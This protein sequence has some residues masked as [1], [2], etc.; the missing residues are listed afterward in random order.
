MYPVTQEAETRLTQREPDWQRPGYHFLPPANWLNDPNGLMHWKGEYHLFYQ[1]NP[2]GPIHGNIH[3]GHAVSTDLVHW[4]HLPIALAP[5]PGSVDEDGCW[6][7]CAIDDQGV[8]TLIYTGLRGGEQ[9]PCLAT[10]SDDL[11]TWQKCADN[12]IIPAPPADLEVIG[13]RDHSLWKEGDTWY[14]V[15]GSGIKGVGGTALLYRSSNLRQ[16]EYLHPLCVG[17]KD[18]TTPVWL[19]S[20]WEC[21]DFFALGDKHVLITSI[22]HE[23]QLHYTVYQ[24]GR[25]AAHHF[26]PET[27]EKLDYGD[28]YFYAPQTVR[29]AQGRR[30]IWGWIQEGRSKP[31]QIAAG[32]SGV[33]SLPRVLSLGTDS[34][35]RQ[36]P[37]P[38]LQ[39]LRRAHRQVPALVL[40]PGQDQV[41]EGMCGDM[42]EIVA[43]FEPGDARQVGLKVRCS[44]DGA[45]E[46]FI[47]YD[48]ATQQLAVDRGRASL[49]PQ[50]ERSI[51]Q[52]TVLLGPGEPL[53]LHIFLDR[54]VVEVFAN[55]GRCLTNRVYPARADSLGAVA[56]AQGGTAR[57]T[58]LESWEMASIWES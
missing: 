30:L 48:V 12:P 50:T 35:V 44:P 47:Y 16:W 55:G 53:K 38:E 46:T 31:A 9:R 25:Y 45:E 54:S 43:E 24:A 42:L 4:T 10:S 56:V 51:R 11:R 58:S 5:T 33:M 14:Q 37:A 15:I 18:Q 19:G 20:M 2:G 26:T 3:W 1:Y 8:P 21:P 34:R 28:N 23:E 6:S 22:W 7:G 41:L 29:D 32:W 13:F 40:P 17:D 36:E 57:L 49:D 39:A 52:G 27:V